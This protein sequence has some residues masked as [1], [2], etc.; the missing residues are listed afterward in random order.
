MQKA[1]QPTA[2][3]KSAIDSF[4]LLHATCKISELEMNTRGKK[5]KHVI[6]V[7]MTIYYNFSSFHDLLTL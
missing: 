2:H 3:R 1:E 5:I 4:H 6:E 7:Y